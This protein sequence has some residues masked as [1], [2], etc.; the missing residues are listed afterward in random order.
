MDEKARTELH[1]WL[2]SLGFTGSF[3]AL[4][5]KLAKLG[6]DSRNRWCWTV[7][8]ARFRSNPRILEVL[9]RIHSL[10]E[11]HFEHSSLSADS[12]SLMGQMD[13]SA[14][15]IAYAHRDVKAITVMMKWVGFDD[16][17]L[18][19]RIIFRFGD[20]YIRDRFITLSRNANK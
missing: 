1:T 19:I 7:F 17:K 5:G 11:K 4:E 14:Q 9:K 3:E 6:R 10:G 2:A 16:D 15:K 18:E 8:D 20:D 13:F 12:Y